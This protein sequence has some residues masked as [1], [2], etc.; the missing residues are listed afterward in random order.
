LGVETNKATH[1][2]TA[3]IASAY[4]L[5]ASKVTL[6]DINNDLPGL[7]W[8]LKHKQRLRKL[9]HETKDPGCKMAANWVM[10]SIRQ[11]THKKALE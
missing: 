6:S 9:W 11:M 8:L 5:L 4:R 3:S 10:K 7:D 2:F 1:D